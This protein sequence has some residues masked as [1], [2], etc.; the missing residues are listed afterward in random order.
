M[1][2]ERNVSQHNNIF[3]KCSLA[4]A[5]RW[6]SS[7]YTVQY[8]TI[9]RGAHNPRLEDDLYLSPPPGILLL[10]SIMLTD[11]RYD[12]QEIEEAGGIKC[13]V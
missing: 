3:S 9:Q 10:Q 4:H 11:V 12:R 7:I 5:R 6:A 13:K 2:T 8:Y 1:S